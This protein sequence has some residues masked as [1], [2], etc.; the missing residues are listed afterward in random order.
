VA[1][2]KSGD[3][4]GGKYVTGRGDGPQIAAAITDQQKRAAGDGKDTTFG[5][6]LVKRRHKE[7]SEHMLEWRKQ[8]DSYE[9]GDRYRN[10]E[11]GPDER[12]LPCRNLFRHR[13]EYPDPQQYPAIFQAMAGVRGGAGGNAASVGVGPLPGMLGADQAATAMDDDYELRRARTPVYPFVREVCDIHLGKVYD[14][15]VTRECSD[16][17]IEA[18]WENVDGRGTTIDDWMRELIAPQQLYYG[19]LDLCFDRPRLPEGAKPPENLAQE[20]ELSLDS[21]VASY[22]L[23]ENMVWW[24][25]D[26]AGRYTQCLV[27]EYIDPSEHEGDECEEPSDIDGDDDIAEEWRKANIQWRHWTSI[28][29]TLYNHNGKEIVGPPIPHNY[30]RVPIVRLMNTRKP[31]T[32]NV[33][34]SQYQATVELQRD[35]YNTDSEV[36]LSNVLQATP[37]LSGPE[38]F[39]KADNTLSVGPGNILPK[40]KNPETGHY[41]GWEYV[42]PPKD[43]FNALQATKL[44]IVDNILRINGLTKP[45][46]TGTGRG[47]EGSGT[48]GQSGLSKQLDAVTGD[49]ILTDIAMSLAKSERI[50]VEYVY[51]VAHCTPPPPA[52]KKDLK[53]GYSTQFELQAADEIAAGAV[54]LQLIMSQCGNAPN[55]EQAIM[56]AMYRKIVPA[57]EDDAYELVDDEF[58]KLV[59]T[60]SLLQEQIH[61]LSAAAMSGDNAFDG[62]GSEESRGGMDD[63]GQSATTLVSPRTPNTFN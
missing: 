37:L 21:V 50:M 58:E 12:G 62:S 63:V 23:P 11:Y 15:E 31:R 30:G 49:K 44:D 41:E 26:L 43:P 39:C 54:Q 3:P 53:V 16:P 61:E 19:N 17:A 40:K 46:G 35:Y 6:K 60:K 48:V 27:R 59:T 45:A 57:L 32:D 1:R 56:S 4:T 24:T 42:S 5:E 51:L 7:Y 52:F 8:A 33:G 28:D 10:A 29:S 9:G 18:W 55:A 20:R 47:G 14:Q 34:F 38:D 25:K 36:K 13:R 22:I 2:K